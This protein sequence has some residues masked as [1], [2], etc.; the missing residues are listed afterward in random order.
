[1]SKFLKA[2]FTG[3]FAGLAISTSAFAAGIDY[4]VGEDVHNINR[5]GF[6]SDATLVSIKGVTS[7][8]NGNAR[9]DMKNLAQSTGEIKVDLVSLD[10]GI[11]RRNEHMKKVINTASNPFAT[12][13]L[14][15][16][17]TKLK[18]LPPYKPVFVNATGDLTINGVTKPVSTV[19]ELTN[20]PEMD[21][22]I[23]EG[24]WIHMVTAFDV[25]LSDHGIKAPSLIPMKV[26]DTIKINVDVMGMQK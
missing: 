3:A 20:M 2:L 9:V 21:K 16:L 4:V 13:K 19:L 12:F 5:V 8:V 25:K 7:N 11:S 22:D 6:I 15:K 17:N 10:T 26:N 14:K 24:N 23:R 1:M 18:A